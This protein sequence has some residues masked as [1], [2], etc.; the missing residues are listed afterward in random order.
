M[1]TVYE[2]ERQTAPA[3]RDADALHV[4]NGPGSLL[5]HYDVTISRPSER[6]PGDVVFEQWLAEAAG[7]SGLSCG[8]IHPGVVEAAVARLHA[9]EMSVGLHMDGATDWRRPEN[10]FVRLAFAVQD[11]GGRPVNSPAL[12][13]AFTDRAAA[14]HEL[15]RHELGAP[16]TV[17]LRPWAPD[18][19]LT[20]PECWRL[21]PDEPGMR[22]W[23]KPANGSGGRGLS[24]VD[25]PTPERVRAAV[26]EARR[27]GPG[28]SY[29]IQ[30]EVRPPWLRCPD[31][32]SRPAHWRV[33]SCLGETTAFWWQ[34][35]ELAPAGAPCYREVTAQETERHGLQ[36]IHD[37]ARALAGVCG[38]DWFSTELCLSPAPG[39]GRFTVRDV[40]GLDLPLTVVDAV[41]AGCDVGVQSQ[42]RT[43]LPDGFVR[44]L[45][46]RFADLAWQVRKRVPPDGMCPPRAA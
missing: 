12:A 27:L 32:V 1:L 24:L 28:D 25:R 30:A 10:P 9:G 15:E 16:P 11:S 41:G 23:I 36:P 5:E 18:R 39:P 17:I 29:L 14:H 44:K 38:L 20:P 22:L 40:D 35:A 42:D 34:P 19:L 4:P 43:G 45:A 7:A 37:C 8:L 26:A 31:G 33:V 3:S 6:L 46:W 21:L 13:M 2:G